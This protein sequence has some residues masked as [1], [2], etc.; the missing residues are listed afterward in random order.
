MSPDD[1]MTRGDRQNLIGI[2]RRRA[3]LADRD[4]ESRA[5]ILLAEVMNDITAEYAAQ[6]RLWRDAVAIA[7]DAAAKANAQIEARCAE[8]GIPPGKGPKLGL[9]WAA[10]CSEYADTKRRA[11]LQKLAKSRLDALTRTAKAEIA[12]RAIAVEETLI[13]GG[14][15]SDAA[16]EMAESLPS[17]EQL[18]PALRLEDLGVKRWQPPEDIAAQ[19][20]SP[21]TATQR[22]RR[23]IMRVIQAR[24]G[25]SNRAIAKA[26]GCD[27]K[28][29]AAIRAERGE[30]PRAW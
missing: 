28:T 27:P 19:L 16:R 9:G 2:V 10:R 26:A 8:L 23:Q 18:M 22:R 1:G 20:T 13:V 21:L 11:E 3:K 7:E 5:A 12:A 14:L 29:V 30:I 4:V 6:D 24:P 25:E 15:Q 17:P